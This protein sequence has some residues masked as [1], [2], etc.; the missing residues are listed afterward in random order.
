MLTESATEL[1]IRSTGERVTPLLINAVDQILIANIQH[2][3]DPK[4]LAAQVEFRAKQLESSQDFD[5][6]N[7]LDV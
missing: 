4:G 6:L 3:L 5:L 7:L 2:N 1:G